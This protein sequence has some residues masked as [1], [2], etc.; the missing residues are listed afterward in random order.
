MLKK[1]VDRWLLVFGGSFYHLSVVCSS[2]LSLL[3]SDSKV[4]RIVHCFSRLLVDEY[5][6]LR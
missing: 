2:K 6:V 1:Q 4:F 5:G 3:S